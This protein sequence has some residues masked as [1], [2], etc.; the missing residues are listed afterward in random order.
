MCP[1]LPWEEVP[2]TV[3]ITYLEASNSLPA[4]MF[5]SNL[6]S[7]VWTNSEHLL[8][9]KDIT[10]IFPVIRM[11]RWQKGNVGNV[12]SL[13]GI[14]RIH[15]CYDT[16]FSLAL[17]LNFSFMT[18]IYAYLT[19][20]TIWF[21]VYSYMFRRKSAIFRKSMHQYLK[22]MKMWY[23]TTVMHIIL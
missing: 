19:Y 9:V 18:P 7:P 23:I 6:H 16:I 5:P 22:L 8:F 17:G 14:S 11:G 2:W 21:F 15:H 4:I 20:I 12:S 1:L 13:W 3:E 10:T